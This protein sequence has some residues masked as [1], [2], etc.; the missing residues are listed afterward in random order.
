MK[1]QVEV[2]IELDALDEEAAYERAYD[3]MSGAWRDG[4]ST[5]T[6][7]HPG[8]DYEMLQGCV[9]EVEDFS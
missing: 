9:T 3:I 7:A 8:W 4:R 1:Y 5:A 6:W 2:L